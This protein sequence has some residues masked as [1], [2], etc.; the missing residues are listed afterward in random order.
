MRYQGR[1]TSWKDDKGFGFITPNGG[2]EPLFVH[3]SALAN[4][5]RRPQGNEL[6]T[7]EVGHDARG[8]L[9]A[10]NV[11]FVGEHSAPTG[12]NKS[13]S[14]FPPLFALGFL[15]FVAAMA[16]LGRLPPII[17]GIYVVT[18]I[19]AFLAYGLDKSAAKR[20][21]WRT[22]ESTLH[23]FA[24]LGG[25][26][27]ALAAQRV[28][29][30]KSAKTSFQIVFWASVALNCGALGWLLSASGASVLRATLGHSS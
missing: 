21:A 17:P 16:M 22:K 11:G 13:R 24:L 12:G 6:V 26:P 1:I 8:R 25:W 28:L 18:S 3:V 27:G 20:N 9:Q 30:H 29:R 10:R 15:A 5:H 14:P 23:L 7:Y 4:R 19:L 2:G